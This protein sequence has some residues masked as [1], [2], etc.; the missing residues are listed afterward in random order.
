MKH[1]SDERIN[2]PAAIKWSMYRTIVVQ[3]ELR[4]KAGLSLYWLLSLVLVNFG[5]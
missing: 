5:E 3:K 4:P 2:A 1:E